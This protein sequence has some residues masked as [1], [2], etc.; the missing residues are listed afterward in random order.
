MRALV[1][2]NKSLRCSLLLLGTID[3]HRLRRF[4]T[5]LELQRRML[6]TGGTRLTRSGRIL[7]PRIGN[8]TISPARRESSSIWINSALIFTAANMSSAHRPSPPVAKVT[9][10]RLVGIEVIQKDAGSCVER[11]R[12]LHHERWRDR[13]AKYLGA[14][15][16]AAARNR[17]SMARQCRT[18]SASPADT[19]CMPVIVPRYRASHGCIRMPAQMARHFFDAAEE[20]TPVIVKRN[21]RIA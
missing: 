10:R 19:A 4:R 14:R 3:V 20:G 5:P 7:Q 1:T 15:R 13:D 17:S 16:S 12:R 21:S 2:D 6:W 18:S 9:K 8:P 11:I